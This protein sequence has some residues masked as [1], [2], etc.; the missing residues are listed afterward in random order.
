M[1]RYC[2]FG[3]TVNTAS[4]MESNGKPG[5]IHISPELNQ[6]LMLLG[7]FHTESRG[8]VIIKGKG[9]METYWLLSSDDVSYPSSTIQPPPVNP[10]VIPDPQ[11][12]M[13]FTRAENTP[14]STKNMYQQFVDGSLTDL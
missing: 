14:K 2:L 6:L 8:E 5:Q 7:G 9:V 1:P 13:I 10:F 11:P 12:D 4:R 3:D